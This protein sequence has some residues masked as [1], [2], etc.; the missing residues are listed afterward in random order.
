MYGLN[1]EE[2]C[3]PSED[4]FE[5]VPWTCGH[6]SLE[7]FEISDLL[8][9]LEETTHQY[10]NPAIMGDPPRTTCERQLLWF[11]GLGLSYQASLSLSHWNK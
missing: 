8:W 2:T 4:L 3:V 9:L 5:P 11:G 6:V 7:P 10:F 1:I